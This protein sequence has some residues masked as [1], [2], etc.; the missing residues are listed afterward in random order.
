MR[1]IQRLGIF[2]PEKSPRLFR[3]LERELRYEFAARSH[4]EL[5]DKIVYEEMFYPEEL[6]KRIKAILRRLRKRKRTTV[7]V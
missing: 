3:E 6:K 5:Y 2:L 7:I 4:D 1:I